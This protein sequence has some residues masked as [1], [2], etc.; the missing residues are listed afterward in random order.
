MSNTFI[1]ADMIAREALPI[2][3]NNLVMANLVHTDFSADFAEM[4]DT[5]QVLKPAN[6]TAIEFDGDL[7][8]QYQDVVESKV[9]VSLDTIATVDM[10]IT[11]KQRT[12]NIRDFTAQ[13]INPAMEA[14][15][16]KID[17]DI[18]GLYADIPYFYGTSGT[19]PD[20]LDDIT[21]ARKILNINKAPMAQRR[22]VID[23]EADAK[24]N[25]LDA[26]V[27]VDKS[28]SALALREAIL[29][30]VSGL[31]M[32]LDQNIPEHAAGT[33]VAVA[34]PTATGTAGESTVALTGGAGAETLL[35]G[36]ILTISGY[37][38]VVTTSTA[39]SGGDIAAA[40]IYP[41]LKT[42]PS[43][44]AVTFPDKTAGGHTA[45]LGFHRSAFALVTR[46]LMAPMGGAESTVMN[47]DGLSVR[48]TFD[49]SMDLK[50][51]IVSFDILY[52]VKTLYKE[53]A[54]RLLG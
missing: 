43:S 27:G 33:F 7:T 11:A 52:G 10:K 5:V 32:Y 23:S 51:D 2:L 25:S 48:V 41:A 14:I 3:R 20:A 4:G 42:S 12:L 44:T 9:D 54:V 1:T 53:L 50:S 18:M 39:A 17:S 46:P 13:I 26:L 34:S 16:Q 36:D 30:R 22:L 49:Y 37:Q 45:N 21:G 35:A 6:F 8:G 19:T 24:L 15:A 47:F 29:G 28:G 38:Y 40:A 31:D